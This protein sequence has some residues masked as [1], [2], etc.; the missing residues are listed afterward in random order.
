MTSRKQII[1][2]ILA[3]EVGNCSNLEQHSIAIRFVDMHCQIREKFLDFIT[4]QR[5]TESALATAIL[6]RLN[7][8]NIDI[9]H[10]RGQCY[11]EA[12]NMSSFRKGVQGR[13]LEVCYF[14]FY[15]HCQTHQLSHCVVKA[16]SVAP[17]RNATSTKFLVAASIAMRLLSFLC[18]V[19]VKL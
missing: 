9:A 5:I 11:D 12:Y 7:I 8:W 13:I 18:G 3:D 15:T 2:S 4:V 14:A 6:D 17:I 19:T 10:C 16:C 1:F